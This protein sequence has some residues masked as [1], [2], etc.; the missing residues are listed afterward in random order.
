M[1]KAKDLINMPVLFVQ[2]GLDNAA[3]RNMAVDPQTLTVRY[4]AVNDGS[5]FAP[6]MLI[7]YDKIA[8]IGADMIAIRSLEDADRVT[9]EETLRKLTPV[10]GT[11]VVD[12]T[13]TRRG[14][15]TDYVLEERN[16][17]VLAFLLDDGTQVD[18]NHIVTFAPR[19][20]VVEVDGS[21]G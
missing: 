20:L 9:D 14:R 16:G 3:I 8:S 17:R 4:L 7:P 15:V 10:W 2:Q 11:P 18:V 19:L 21:G 12:E 13:G 6:V 1:R 5:W